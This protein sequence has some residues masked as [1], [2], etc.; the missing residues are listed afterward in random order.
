MES[1]YDPT[2]KAN[3]YFCMA[4]LIQYIRAQSD[5]SSVLTSWKAQLGK[6]L[7]WE[8]DGEKM[9]HNLRGIKS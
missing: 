4:L 2:F 6:K 1:F 7:I 9:L 8:P 3:G 5:E